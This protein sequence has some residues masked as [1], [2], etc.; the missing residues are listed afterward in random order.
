MGPEFF[1]Q[2]VGTLYHCLAE[3]N[4]FEW[5]QGDMIFDLISVFVQSGFNF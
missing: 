2:V 5:R 4:S 3:M 1:L